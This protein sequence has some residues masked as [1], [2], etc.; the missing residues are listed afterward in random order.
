MPSF[1]DNEF[2]EIT[3]RR[4]NMSKSIK[5]SVGPTGSLRIS[6]PTYVPLIMAKR[7]INQSRA[8]IRKIYNSQPR[9]N[10]SDGMT[11]GKSHS[12]HVRSGTDIR[13]QASGTQIVVTL[14]IGTT[15]DD[16]AVDSLLR[17]KVRKALRVEAKHYLPK[18]LAY[19]ANEHA[20]TYESVR[21]SHASSR[22]G[23]CSS[24]GTISLNIALMMLPF[25]LI[26]YVL[27]H[28]LA[29]T[30]QMNHSNEFWDIVQSV[31]PNYKAYRKQLKQHTPTI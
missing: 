25:E 2:G 3:V 30:K 29:H 8:E 21:F 19:L 7:M 17:E 15:L 10:F 16:P 9:L 12:L 28:E 20:F 14:P 31:S 5:V 22:W 4:S 18:R 26:D 11:I 13:V 1:H 27:L 23:S 6:M 24:R